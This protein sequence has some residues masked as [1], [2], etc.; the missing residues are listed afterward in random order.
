MKIQVKN[1]L[2]FFSRWS[3]KKLYII[4]AFHF[5]PCS[6]IILYF[7]IFFKNSTQQMTVLDL[8]STPGF[9][10]N[11][12]M[13]WISN[14][15]LITLRFLLMK[16][17]LRFK[18]TFFRSILYLTHHTENMY[19]SIETDKCLNKKLQKR[20]NATQRLLNGNKLMPQQRHRK[21]MFLILLS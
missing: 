21:L 12:I 1:L 13:T 5:T 4:W 2:Y 16:E 18:S 15:W 8:I 17:S 10:F 14:T 19:N 6:S 9:M 20:W 3:K 11:I 7:K